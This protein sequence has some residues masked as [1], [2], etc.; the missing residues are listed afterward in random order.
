MMKISLKMDNKMVNQAKTNKTKI[1]NK[2]NNLNKIVNIKNNQKSMMQP[3]VVKI[4]TQII[5]S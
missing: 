4:L 3:T 1:N 2:N 5:K